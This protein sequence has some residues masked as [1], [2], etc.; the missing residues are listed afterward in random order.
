MGRFTPEQQGA[1][2]SAGAA[3]WLHTIVLLCGEATVCPAYLTH[4]V[5]HYFVYLFFFFLFFS[6]ALGLKFPSQ[7][8]NPHH[9]SDMSY[10]SDNIRSLT[11][12][13][14]RDSQAHC[15]TDTPLCIIFSNNSKI[16]WN[17]RE[18]PSWLSDNESD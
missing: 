7:G 6:F 15:L 14:P 1:V 17:N 13:P 11:T 9:S 4:R 8:L 5:D 3:L 18:S 16:K 10:S 2:C 12:R